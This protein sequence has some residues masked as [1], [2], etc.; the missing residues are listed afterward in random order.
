MEK[1]GQP[2]KFSIEIDYY[3]ILYKDDP[4]YINDGPSYKC[5]GHA[6][7][8]VNG[9]NLFDKLNDGNEHTFTGD[10][11]VLFDFF[12][13]NLIYHITD[14]PFPIKTRSSVGREMIEEVKLIEGRDNDLQ[15]Y[16]EV[17]WESVDMELYGNVDLWNVRHGLLTNDGGFFLPNG[18]FQKIGN[19]IE[20]SWQDDYP[21][22]SAFGNFYFKY[23]KGVEYIDIK[24]YKDTIVA[25]CLDFIERFKGIYP[26]LEKDRAELQKAI[27]IIV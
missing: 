16:T 6:R 9:R 27:D 22:K 21:R 19:K 18:F 2:N 15:K 23:P 10:V 8:L 25:F 1:F 24:L 5:G 26:K 4:E 12:C 11:G 17:D 7:F 13:N 20:Y 14:D 3:Y